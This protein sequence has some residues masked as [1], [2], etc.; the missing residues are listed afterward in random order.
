MEKLYIIPI[1]PWQRN[2]FLTIKTV[3][4]WQRTKT[5]EDNNRSPYGDPNL[6]SYYFKNRVL[7]QQAR[8][9]AYVHQNQFLTG[10]KNQEERT[11][12]KH[13]TKDKR[14][15]I[16]RHSGNRKRVKPKATTS[17]DPYFSTT[18]TYAILH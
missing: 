18:S 14:S 12:A 15:N 1:Q 10:T 4:L 17:D 7:S 3:S 6:S 9:R 16:D 13:P 2:G 8:P 11:R 5:Y